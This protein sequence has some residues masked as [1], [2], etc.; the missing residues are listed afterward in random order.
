MKERIIY[1]KDELNDDFARTKNHSRIIIN[2]KYNYMREKNIFWR[3]LSYFLH[4][5][6]V[7]PVSHLIM[8]FYLQSYND[9]QIP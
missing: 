3:M 7:K 6:I 5:I 4:Y 2:G 1:Y 8:L 9:T